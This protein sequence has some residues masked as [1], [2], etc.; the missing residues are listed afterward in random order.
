MSKCLSCGKPV[1]IKLVRH[2]GLCSAC[3]HFKA[4]WAKVKQY[5]KAAKDRY[6]DRKYLLQ[7]RKYRKTKAGKLSQKNRH[8]R[9]NTRHPERVKKQHQDYLRKNREYVLSYN[10]EYRRKNKRFRIYTASVRALRDLY[11]RKS[12]NI[13]LIIKHERIIND[14]KRYK[15]G[16]R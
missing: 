14:Y 4:Y 7:I 8:L 9:Y 10:R 2:S 6:H 16:N 13:E 11:K 3:R 1:T 15:N 12:I 5:R